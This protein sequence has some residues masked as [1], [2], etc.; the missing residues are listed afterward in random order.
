MRIFLTGATGFIGKALVCL[1]LREGH[2]VFA[3]VRKISSELPTAVKQVEIGDLLNI[4]DEKLD[5]YLSPILSACDVFIHLAGLAH[6]NIGQSNEQFLF[7][8]VNVKATL[9]L[10]KLA[11]INKVKRFIFLSSI[12]VNGNQTNV[13][14]FTE[15]D[16]PSPKEPYAISKWEA[17]ELLKSQLSEEQMEYVI[18]RPP[19]VYGPNAPGNFKTLVKWSK[20]RIPLPFGAV[21][22]RRSMI[23]LD[24]LT[25]FIAV[26]IKN[27]DAGNETF[28]IADD[29][30]VSLSCLLKRVA[31]SYGQKARMISIPVGIIEHSLRLIGKTSLITPL[32]RD[33]QVDSS[34]AK[35]V[36]RWQ[37]IIAM[38]QQLEK[39]AD[40]DRNK[41]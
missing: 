3:G 13:Q 1:L 23:A 26:C 7:K 32:I 33:L 19:L 22:N 37:P 12:G 20:K 2:E 25:N 29:E 24:N 27:P 21:H 16:S 6:I 34:K 9:I 35:Q 15:N 39:M 38:D 40:F 5:L 8:D 4:A 17:E 28:V 36:L 18:I 31:A 14:P 10:A 30:V 41:K 11:S